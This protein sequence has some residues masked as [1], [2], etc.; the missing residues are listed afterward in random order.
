MWWKSEAICAACR[1]KKSASVLTACIVF[2]VAAGEP[3]FCART[4][5]F[6]VRANGA[7]HVLVRSGAPR[8]TEQVLVGFFPIRAA[9]PG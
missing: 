7:D 9:F 8:W 4:P 2:G 1:I 3:V 5:F 6:T